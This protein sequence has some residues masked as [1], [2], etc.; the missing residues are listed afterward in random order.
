MFGNKRIDKLEKLLESIGKKL[1]DSIQEIIC[2]N[3]EIDNLKTLIYPSAKTDIRQALLEQKWEQTRIETGLE[4]DKN[5]K[6]LGQK[7][8]ILQEQLHEEMLKKERNEEDVKEIKGK[9]EILN[10]V[11]GRT[12]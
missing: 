3:K 8:V 12:L 6:T 7:L 11:I 4:T 2:L 9:L 5:I 1:S 10:M